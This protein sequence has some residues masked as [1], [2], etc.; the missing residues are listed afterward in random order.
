M[1]RICYQRACIQTHF[2]A[3]SYSQSVFSHGELLW[4]VQQGGGN[5]PESMEVEGR[6]ITMDTVLPLGT[7]IPAAL[8]K[9]V[10]VSGGELD[11]RL[12]G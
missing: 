11:E 4:W 10:Y 2:H 5:E 9:L 12:R 8:T 3:D 1:K 7:F 6:S